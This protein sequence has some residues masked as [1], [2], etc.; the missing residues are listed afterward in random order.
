MKSLFKRFAAFMFCVVMTFAL[1]GDLG[2]ALPIFA[3]T[4]PTSY[5]ANTWY[6]N[7]LAFDVIHRRAYDND[8]VIYHEVIYDNTHSFDNK[9]G[10]DKQITYDENSGIITVDSFDGY[11][12]YGVFVGFAV[13]AG[14]DIVSFDTVDGKEVLKIDYGSV[15]N[16]T[17]PV[18]EVKINVFYMEEPQYGADFGAGTSAGTG[19]ENDVCYIALDKNGDILEK[20]DTDVTDKLEDR[21]YIVDPDWV[22]TDI[23]GNLSANSNFEKKY[24]FEADGVA[25]LYNTSAG[26]HTD[27]TV[28]ATENRGDGIDG[29]RE[30]DV[31]LE[32]WYGG[33][34]TADI[35]LILDASG[36]MAFTASDMI[37]MRLGQGS[38]L[39]R[40]Q[41]FTWLNHDI[42]DVTYSYDKEL[43]ER[44]KSKYGDFTLSYD[45][46]FKKYTITFDG[47]GYYPDGEYSFNANEY[48]PPDIVDILL[49]RTDTDNS[50]LGYSGY[51]YYVYDRRGSH[52]EF[53][54]LGYWGG[55][56]SLTKPYTKT[57]PY[58][59][60]EKLIGH[61]TFDSSLKNE[62]SSGDGEA[63]L[64]NNVEKSETFDKNSAPKET[65]APTYLKNDTKTLDLAATAKQGALLSDVQATESFT[66]S[67]RVKVSDLKADKNSVDKTPLVYVGK[68]NNNYITVYRSGSG[69]DPTRL[70]VDVGGQT[71]V[72]NVGKLFQT[73]DSNKCGTDSWVNISLSYDNS[74]KKVSIDL[75]ANGMDDTDK[76]NRKYIKQFTYDATDLNLDFKGADIII[77]GDVV[78]NSESK[79]Y[80]EVQ[81]TEFC[82]FSKSLDSA[83]LAKVNNSND[84]KTFNT[85]KDLGNLVAYYDFGD[86]G[87]GEHEQL[88]N[89]VDTSKSLTF[90]E[91][92]K[93][94]A[95]TKT[96]LTGAAELEPDY[97]DGALNLT[98]TA[99]K[100]GILLDIIPTDKN[101]FSISFKVKNVKNDTPTHEAE[102]VYM[103]PLNTTEGYYNIFR[104]QNETETKSGDSRHIRF[105]KDSNYGTKA[106][107]SNAFNQNQNPWKTVTFTVNNGAV[108]AYVDGAKSTG[109][110]ESDAA[111][112]T[113]SANDF[114]IILGG[115]QDEYDGEDILIDEL[116]V[117][118]KALDESEVSQLYKSLQEPEEIASE[119]Y[120]ALDDSKKNIIASIDAALVSEGHEEDM[121]G[122]YYVNSTSN[123]DKNYNNPEVGTAKVFQ[124]LSKD[125]VIK[126]EI[127][128]NDLPE[129]IQA[130]LEKGW[131]DFKECNGGFIYT[132][133]NDFTLTD[134]SAHYYYD[135]DYDA[136][137][138]EGKPS[139]YITDIKEYD[140]ADALG[141]NEGKAAI[142]VPA[143][144]TRSGNEKQSPVIFFIDN[145]GFLR[146]FYSSSNSKTE[147]G[148]TSGPRSSASY[149]YFKWDCEDTKTDSLQA[150]LGIFNTELEQISPSS[151]VSAVR[152]SSA[153]VKDDKDSLSKLVML[154]WTKDPA[155]A[156]KMLSLEYGDGSSTGSELSTPSAENENSSQSPMPQY[157]YG[158][159]GGTSTYQG[160]KAFEDILLP[161]I[162][163]D[164][165]ERNEGES[166]Y[167]IVFTDGKDTNVEDTDDTDAQNRVTYSQEIAQRL[168]EKG[169][170]IFYVLLKCGAFATIDDSEKTFIASI[171]GNTD[172]ASCGYDDLLN[173]TSTDGHKYVFEATGA[174]GLTNVFRNDILNEITK[175]LNDYTVKD[176]IDPR[177][178]IVGYTFDSGNYGVKT[179]FHLNE[180]GKVEYIDALDNEEKS[181]TINA[182]TP[183]EI[184]L[185]SDYGSSEAL[186]LYY[187]GGGYYVAWDKQDI[188][189]CTV[190]D[191]ELTVWRSEF[192]IVAKE[193]FI[194]GNAILTNGSEEKQNYV[195]NPDDNNAEGELI[196]SSG[197]D[198]ANVDISSGGYVSKGF[199]RTAANVRRLPLE[200]TESNSD[201]YLGEKISPEDI[202]TALVE[203][204]I[205]DNKTGS[206]YFEYLLRT[207]DNKTKLAELF[208]G[209]EDGE[210]T[211]TLP[212]AYLKS[213][214]DADS[215]AGDN[216]HQGDIIG[217]I[218]YTLKD[219]TDNLDSGETIDKDGGSVIT[220]YAK[221]RKYTLTVGFDPF[222]VKSDSSVVGGVETDRNTANGTLVGDGNYKWDR[223]F[224]PA[225]GA[226]QSGFSEI[227]NTHTVDM[228]RG[229]IVLRAVLSDADYDY[230]CKYYPDT[231]LFSADLTRNYGGNDITVGTFTVRTPA[232]AS[233]ASTGEKYLYAEFVPA[234]ETA[235][236]DLL[237]T[238][239]YTFDNAK[240]NDDLPI[241]FDTVKLVEDLTDALDRFNNYVYLD[242][243][244]MQTA[245]SGNAGHK[246]SYT[247]A[248]STVKLG[249]ASTGADRLD[250]LLGLAEIRG[251]LKTGSL[252]ISKTVVDKSSDFA[253][254]GDE[255][256]TFNV[257]FFNGANELTADDFD[258]IN[259]SINGAPETSFDG[260]VKLKADENAV[261]SGIPVG[262]TYTVE[263]QPVDN[264]T[265]EYTFSDETKTISDDD[266][267]TVEVTNTYELSVPATIS[268]E[269][270]IKGEYLPDRETSFEFKIAPDTANG[271]AAPG[272]YPTVEE[273][274]VTI[275]FEATP[276]GDVTTSKTNSGSWDLTFKKV[277]TYCYTVTETVP[278][279][280]KGF[281]YDEKTVHTVVF[282]VEKD[283][284]DKKLNVTTTVDNEPADK[285]SYTNTYAP[286]EIEVYFDGTKELTGRDW[287]TGD[288]FEFTIEGDEP[289][290]T[291][292][293]V[294][295]DS[296]NHGFTFGAITFTKPGE[297]TYTIKET[298]GTDDKIVYD[299][300]EYTVTVNVTDNGG[301]LESTY[302]I[303][304]GDT[305]ID[306]GDIVDNHIK[307][308]DFENIYTPAA[309]EIEVSGAKNFTIEDGEAPEPDEEFTFT[310]NAVETDKGWAEI[311]SPESKTVAF[312]GSE[313]SS[314]NTS[315]K[316]I[317]DLLKKTFELEDIPAIKDGGSVNYYYKVTEE[318]GNAN[319]VS[320]DAAEYHI[321]VMVSYSKEDGVLSANYDVTDAMGVTA[322]IVFSNTYTPEA[323]PVTANVTVIKDIDGDGLPSGENFTF[324]F[325]VTETDEKHEPLAGAAQISPITVTNEG[326]A[327]FITRKFAASDI[328]KTFYYTVAETDL[329]DPHF[330]C[331]DHVEYITV[332]VGYDPATNTVTAVPSVSEVTFTNT[333]TP[334]AIPATANVTVKKDIDG[335][336]LPSG[337]SFTF[338]F[339]VAETDENR[340]PLAG[341]AQISPI[342]VTNEGAAAFITRKFAASDIGKTFYYTVAETDLNDPHFDCDD[343]VEYITVTVGYDPA[344]NTVTAEPSV[345]EVTFTN[346]YTAPKPHITITKSQTAVNGLSGT[347]LTVKADDIVEYTV[348]VFND[349]DADAPAVKVIDPVPTGLII[350]D[351]GSGTLDGQNITWTLSVGA[352]SQTAVSFRVKVPPVTA[353]TTWRNI[354]YADGTPSETVVLIEEKPK[355]G[356]VEVRKTLTGNDFNP[357]DRFSFTIDVYGDDGITPILSEMFELGQGES[358]KFENLPD[359]AKFTVSEVENIL[360]Y[361][362]SVNG[363]SGNYYTG[364]VENN[365]TVSVKF[366]NERSKP[367]VQTGSLIVRKTVAG[368]AEAIIPETFGFAY[369]LGLPSDFTDTE[370]DYTISHFDYMGV[371]VIDESG[372]LGTMG[373]FSLNNGQRIK[374][375]GLPAGTAY[376]VDE[377]EAVGSYI[378]DRYNTSGVIAIDGNGA[379]ADA[380]A[381][382]VNTIKTG[383][384][385]VSKTAVGN[386]AKSTDIF[387]FAVSLYHDAALS[388]PAQEVS[389]QFGGMYFEA[390]VDA[391]IAL[392]DGESVTAVGLPV[393][394]YYKIE[395]IGTNGYESGVAGEQIGV[396]ATGMISDA[397][398]SSA[399]FVNLKQKN[400]RTGDLT[401]SKIVTGDGDASYAFPFTLELY[402]HDTAGSPEVLAADV[403]LTGKIV[404][405]VPRDVSVT[406]GY[407]AFSLKHGE[408]LRLEGLPEDIHY[409]I[410]ETD[411]NGHT[412]TISNTGAFTP[413]YYDPFYGIMT[414]AETPS[415]AAAGDVKGGEH[416]SVTFYN[417]VEPEP[418]P[419][420]ANTS[421]SITKTFDQAGAT[422]DNALTFSFDVELISAFDPSGSPI[423][424][425]SGNHLANVTVNKGDEEGYGTVDLSF[426]RAGTYT[427]SIKER[428][429]YI[430]DA[431]EGGE[432]YTVIDEKLA[433]VTVTEVN[434]IL[435]A[436]PIE[437]IVFENHYVAPKAPPTPSSAEITVQKLIEGDDIG[438]E[439]FTFDFTVTETDQSGVPLTGDIIGELHITGE[440]ADT[441][442][443]R[444][445]T[446]S[447]IGSSFYYMITETDGGVKGMSYA[448]AQLVTVSVT[449]DDENNA[450]VATA[451]PNPVVFINTYTRPDPDLAEIR[452]TKKVLD[453][454]GK[455]YAEG[456][457][458]F[459]VS[460]TN[461]PEYSEN[462]FANGKAAVSVDG[463]AT[464]VLT[465]PFGAE[466]EITEINVPDGYTDS[467][468][469]L[470]GVAD[471]GTVGLIYNN[472]KTVEAPKTGS[473]T[474]SK[475]LVADG[476]TVKG[477]RKFTFKI[478]L[479]GSDF[480]GDANGVRFDNGVARAELNGGESVTMTGL[481]AGVQ[482][483]VTEEHAYGYY[484]LSG[485]S[486]GLS[487]IIT[488][489]SESKAVAVNETVTAR[490]PSYPSRPV[491]D[492]VPEDAVEI[493]T[494]TEGGSSESKE[495][496]PDE[497]VPNPITG[498]LGSG[499]ALLLAA[500]IAPAV[501]RR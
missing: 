451:S 403:N 292:R 431:P 108:T 290:P 481:P 457:F 253:P 314:G 242:S 199:P 294:S 4:T 243:G 339:T 65:I 147:A 20:P 46:S 491:P 359:G 383:Q 73:T 110:V 62:K 106:S 275:N 228:V 178:D 45:E 473:L 386:L 391:N 142:T 237:P 312:Y 305:S 118:D 168:K 171:A 395:E 411:P 287:V 18:H 39:G 195:Y 52:S 71:A 500:A 101:N 398:T 406:G 416:V 471:V 98:E 264:F 251:T 123:W 450:V 442:I 420:P 234:S 382:F 159:T 180:G 475:I 214:N 72:I 22:V 92:A 352:H 114:N 14:N 321:T 130:K 469:K 372:T 495:E 244:N 11:D 349:G 90:I 174:E 265:T 323:I 357:G 209:L 240:P 177:F 246:A 309:A 247:S 387:G 459:E 315:Q 479:L 408:S 83:E 146:C 48:L 5:E 329:N 144:V 440:G 409:I 389:G 392:A 487:G 346:T 103:G 311:G 493:I 393:G 262:V 465:V 30:F 430:G 402:Y 286:D 252:A 126:N 222:N 116:F 291:Q 34:A 225:A 49:K 95:F 162:T 157:N 296:N 455:E 155:A 344:T 443:T 464:V 231:E 61:Y 384:L 353:R 78:N 410:T 88:D 413:T 102:L 255:E 377:L 190:G 29:S 494:P 75:S 36:S 223:G 438:G 200:K 317:V 218:T 80:S 129:N 414:V 198:K 474:L 293:E 164:D 306:S 175:T 268:V 345:S 170:T 342:T 341:A 160:L 499:I 187:D 12:G 236:K 462:G 219:E 367:V 422:K 206:P 156:A 436:T 135:A 397:E 279:D 69:S 354:A 333:Y 143:D 215:Y 23:Y 148:N 254:D 248:E 67:M 212:Y 59:A 38:N 185:S 364:V 426:E 1:V 105:S 467:T 470:K 96:Q 370:F 211:L 376:Q 163:R 87:N 434:G 137:E 378:V 458:S 66:V 213:E 16:G 308:F 449:Y 173:G 313:L 418:E 276:A 40:E 480:T 119:M 145:E 433:V 497:S 325:T 9:G 189:Y 441:F 136:E 404:G 324:T 91:Q 10:G 124:A 56:Y 424:N 358:K 210:E 172:T 31:T 369:S 183:L 472:I 401:V 320:Y 227:V 93:D 460:L 128:I 64:I 304:V 191:S 27:K 60:A 350:D 379:V 81:L 216:A 327:A 76:A 343:H 250:N 7:A 117:Y 32:S 428:A 153:Q 492:T 348:T 368:L 483:A 19:D 120:V 295:V 319:H 298:A 13:L 302:D 285:V 448:D 107:G 445:F 278:S 196:A 374:I 245:S 444:K 259:V 113:L 8:P 134:G 477:G 486:S 193:D 338:T 316:Q 337:E 390:G 256:F 208:E 266:G 197:K 297:Y 141:P 233:A 394:L 50:K 405:S 204:K 415:N 47:K 44:A 63:K 307:G 139:G 115:L 361:T 138:N 267:D 125:E 437:P 332:T 421:L 41:A 24:Q 28:Y 140:Y 340:E 289:L 439:S 6:T 466:Y 476:R 217:N 299:D 165:S 429:K 365:K 482:Y 79:T 284:V 432:L 226:V 363:V 104:S 85:M 249:T 356:S 331:D 258:N 224:K 57:T 380:Y 17:M 82:V 303:K 373:T 43:A 53:N 484:L 207:D 184:K 152:F 277:G 26:L 270:T 21:F 322:D 84:I 238:G 112:D 86:T 261:I 220:L 51:S 2:G 169:F 192:K 478:E 496:V 412:V 282:D 281:V 70:K 179:V 77:G 330:D 347:P 166:K 447:D 232:V 203:Q 132:G 239:D 133:E 435:A 488:A 241:E 318:T 463:G 501:K 366:E 109:G 360:G 74:S 257:K 407:A 127:S 97:T 167:V 201:I 399:A 202:M 381:V 181:Q 490:V 188:P 446:A 271:T 375:S 42:D 396:I 205:A 15:K 273:D 371:E 351:I 194:G 485:N 452:L 425:A 3:A 121:R 335:D 150:A 89:L 400:V 230:L 182:S 283:T 388:E 33:N 272:D 149:V 54:P 456:S 186:N 417:H 468:E 498:T 94:G 263:E 25:K 336:G 131:N 334:E 461:R 454:G 274:T 423:T 68:D 122:W 161:R 229:Q 269:K 280:T 453:S 35:G 362:P 221:G 154:D 235:L 158:L 326:A 385:T 419:E 151:R 301:T 100:G 55:N 58:P 37:P 99:K 176:Y 260:T 489:D 328:G 310:F 288:K 111:L 300:T 427:Y 355:V